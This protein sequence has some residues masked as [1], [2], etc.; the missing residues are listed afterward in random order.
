MAKT[1]NHNLRAKLDLR[2]YFLRKY[3]SNEP[4]RVLDCCQGSGVI[5][6]QL[7]REFDIGSYWGV[8]VKP[9]A[10]RLKIDSVRILQQPGWTQNV[11]DID[12]YGSP[13]KHW[14][15][16]LSMV[17]GPVTVLLTIGRGGP[18]RIR[19]GREELCA[20]GLPVRVHEM[21][22]AITHRLVEMAI[23]HVLAMTQQ[24]GITILEAIEAISDGNA[25]YI[26]V[27]L[28]RNRPGWNR[29]DAEHE[30]AVKE[31]AHV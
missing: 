4:A 14:A 5:W 7:R 19:L 29:A 25:R 24:Y 1:D 6:R 21:S 22:G 13:W 26:G 9:Q 12:T 28:E 18:N 3:H 16:M 2:R 11:I 17:N 31:P 15:A 10:G 30:Q 27:R 23:S 8:D 20:L